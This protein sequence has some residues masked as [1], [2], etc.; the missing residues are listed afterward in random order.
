MQYNIRLATEKDIARI[1]YII[2]LA[3]FNLARNS[4]FHYIFNFSYLLICFLRKKKPKLMIIL[5]LSLG[6]ILSYFLFSL[7]YLATN[8][9]S[10]KN[11]SKNDQV[12]IVNEKNNKIM[13]LISLA[14]SG[15]GGFIRYGFLH[16]KIQRKGFGSFS[17]LLIFQL[18]KQRNYSHISMATTG[19]AKSK[20]LFQKLAGK[21]TNIIKFHKFKKRMIPFDQID[22]EVNQLSF[23]HFNK[24]FQ[25]STEKLHQNGFVINFEKIF[26]VLL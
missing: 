15:S 18:A 1:N 24:I 23:N 16:P 6:V 20:K 25:Q 17:L 3:M 8:Y 26:S 12:F 13:G 22:I 11:F 14:S 5:K 19:L 2:F 9:V 4:I 10:K 7:Y 21:T